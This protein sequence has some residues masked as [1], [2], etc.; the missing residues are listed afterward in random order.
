[1]DPV[2]PT[3]RAD[4]ALLRS[5]RTLGDGTVVYDAVLVRTG[6]PLV[7]EWGEEWVAD[8]AITEE[9][10][11]GLRGLSVTTQDTARHVTGGK[12]VSVRSDARAVG[13]I[14]DAR[15]EAS[16][17]VVE[18]AVH[19]GPTLSRIESGELRELS[20]Q[21]TPRMEQRDGR[22]WQVARESNTVAI[23]SRGRVPG[24][25]L[26]ADQE[27]GVTEE[28][29][30]AAIEATLRADRAE[31]ETLKEARQRA[32][33]AEAELAKLREAVG[34]RADSDD[35]GG[36]IEARV[37]ERVRADAALLERARELGVE[38][39]ESSTPG[40]RAADLAIALGGDR[41]RAD[42]ADYCQGVIDS[43]R[44]TT[45]TDTRADAGDYQPRRLV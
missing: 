11:T 40:T 45:D 9:Y 23:V 25:T 27:D 37:T 12:P 13:T 15:R 39:P 20:E 42:S 36:A 33:A 19:D 43:A 24:A 17:V 14:V 2:I 22:A 4:R 29:I 10:L 28:Q 5:P 34:V 38:L 44:P 1:M 41:Q 3:T 32:D 18:V 31:R 6:V 21:Y 8:E 35:V 26:R 16:A 30:K 7:Y